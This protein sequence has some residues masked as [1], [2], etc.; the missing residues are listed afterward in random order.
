MGREAEALPSLLPLFSFSLLLFL[1][2]FAKV[3]VET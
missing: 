1:L 2:D 3:G